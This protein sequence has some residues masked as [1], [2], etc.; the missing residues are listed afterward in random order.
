VLTILHDCYVLASRDL[1]MEEKIANADVW[2]RILS[3]TIPENRLKECFEM[4]VR[5]HSTTFPVNAHELLIAWGAI[6]KI[7]KPQWQ[8]DRENCT[9]CDERGYVLVD[10][11]HQVCKHI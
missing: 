1:S 4:A 10:G 5:E 3:P 6:T 7:D 11:K 2:S 8:I 9:Q